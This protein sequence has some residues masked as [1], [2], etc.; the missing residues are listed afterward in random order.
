MPLAGRM[1]L[2]TFLAFALPLIAALGLA[3]GFWVKGEMEER[4]RIQA[5]ERRALEAEIEA[6][7]ARQRTAAAE[8]A[9]AAK[10]AAAERRAA[11]EKAAAE[12]AEREKAIA[13]LKPHEKELILTWAGQD[14]RSEKRK[15]VSRGKPWKINVYQ[16]AGHSSVNRAK[17]DLDRDGPD[18]IWDEKWTFSDG[19]ITRKRS[20]RDDG[21]YDIEEVFDGTSF[22]PAQ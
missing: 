15:D 4:E 22:V 3:G 12:R 10:K 14:L 18:S 1:R 8:R 11:E 7:Q 20:S 21:T 16:D 5:E 17:V 13:H 9:E 2:K 19:G 6:E